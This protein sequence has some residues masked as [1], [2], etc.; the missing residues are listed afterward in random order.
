MTI[1]P[2]PE[3][4]LT[5]AQVHELHRKADDLMQQI[6]RKETGISEAEV[7]HLF[8]DALLLKGAAWALGHGFIHQIV[9]Q[10]GTASPCPSR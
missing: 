5:N 1:R 10:D 8:P 6:Y 4:D 2:P 9:G 7:V 3:V